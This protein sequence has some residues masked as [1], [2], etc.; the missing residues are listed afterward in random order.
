MR[1][2]PADRV[3]AVAAMVVVTLMS[4]ACRARESQPVVRAAAPVSDFLLSAGDSTFWITTGPQGVRV[5]GSPLVLAHYNGRF[6]EVYVADEDHSFY[7]AVF[8]T[9]RIPSRSP[10]RGL[11]RRLPRHR[12]CGR[13]PP[14]CTSPPA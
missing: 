10:D 9:Q 5:R 12:H 4:G 2:L 11:C 14:L 1:D 3:P 6:Y 7:D 13:R 8:T